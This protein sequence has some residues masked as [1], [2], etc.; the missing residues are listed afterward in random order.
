M[1]GGTVH[2]IALTEVC[3]KV[4][5]AARHA[6]K[7]A[8]LLEKEQP[9]RAANT[10]FEFGATLLVVKKSGAEIVNAPFN[11]SLTEICGRQFEAVVIV[12]VG[13]IV[14]AI[15]EELKNLISKRKYNK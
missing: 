13:H 3:V 1:A 10:L 7:A 5:L 8:G 6:G 14:R 2:R 11:A 12:D 4:N 9:G 15:N